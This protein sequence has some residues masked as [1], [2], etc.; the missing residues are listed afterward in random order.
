MAS[1]IPTL[2]DNGSLMY[3]NLNI[4]RDTNKDIINAIYNAYNDEAVALA[5]I[6]YGTIMQR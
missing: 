3:V 4:S 1:A 6:Y 2:V 5:K